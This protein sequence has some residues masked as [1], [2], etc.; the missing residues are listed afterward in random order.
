MSEQATA[1]LSDSSTALPEGAVPS[2]EYAETMRSAQ[3]SDPIPAPAQPLSPNKR[4]DH[5]PEKFWDPVKG[6]ARWEDLAKSYVELEKRAAKPEENPEA[7]PQDDPKADPDGPKTAKIE[8]KDG[9]ANPV[10]T[11]IESFES[12]FE[13]KAGALEDADFKALEDA[14][15]P[16]AKID[17]YIAGLAALAEKAMGEVFAVAGGQEQFATV[18]TW[19]AANLNDQ[20]L[21]YYNDNIDNPTT[22]KQTAEWLMAKFSAAN[23]SEGK[24]VEG[25]APT[26]NAGDVYTSQAQVTEAMSDRRYTTDPAYRQAVAEKLLRSKRA[27]SISLG[28]EFYRRS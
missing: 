1:P 26:A 9:D 27:N 23:P 13:T 28:A 4:P 24:R 14:G 25:L 15:I 5:V 19:A 20:D 21:A 22:R 6:E 2:A 10:T 3:H 12:V 17:I 11:A 7:K 16:R 18:Q 8:R